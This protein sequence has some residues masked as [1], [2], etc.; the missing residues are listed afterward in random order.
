MAESMRA[1]TY[2]GCSGTRAYLESWRMTIF[3]ERGEITV[4]W[5]ELSELPDDVASKNT[6]ERVKPGAGPWK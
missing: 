1:S 2:V 4:Y 3:D 6:A 5:T